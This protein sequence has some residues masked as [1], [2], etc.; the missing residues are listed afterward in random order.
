MVNVFNSGA[1]PVP[2]PM[3]RRHTMNHFDC[4]RVRVTRD[5]YRKDGTPVICGPEDR[6]KLI[7]GV[8]AD[9]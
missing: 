3:S 9:A 6:G 4:P 5:L 2:G 1:G 7:G 8:R